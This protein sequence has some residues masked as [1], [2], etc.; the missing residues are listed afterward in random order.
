MSAWSCGC[1]W[2]IDVGGSMMGNGGG[3]EEEGEGAGDSV[4]P[5]QPYFEDNMS[6]GSL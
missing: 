2:L 4:A 1:H 6:V 3:Q 5:E